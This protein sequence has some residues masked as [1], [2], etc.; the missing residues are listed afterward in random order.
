MPTDGT[1]NAKVERRLAAILAADI[2]G[3]SALTRRPPPTMNTCHYGIDTPTRGE[4]IAAN[5]SVEEI[6]K[7]IEADS[8]GYLSVEGMLAAFGRPLQS[9]CTACFTGIYPVEIEEEEREKE[10]ALDVK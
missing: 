7:Y 10:H 8:L 4:L 9:T 1:G 3:Y 5:Q 2:A 6:Q